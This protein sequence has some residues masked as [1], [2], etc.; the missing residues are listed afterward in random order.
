MWSNKTLAPLMVRESEAARQLLGL[1]S[2]SECQWRVV[3]ANKT[4][5]GVIGA[6]GGRERPSARRMSEWCGGSTSAR[7]KG[8]LE[9]IYCW[10]CT[11][12]I[13]AVTPCFVCTP[14]KLQVENRSGHNWTRKAEFLSTM[15][16]SMASKVNRANLY[17]K[18]AS[19][20]QISSLLVL[21]GQS[22]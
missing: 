16:T 4:N 14:C 17:F 12:L 20:G 7:L 2:S 21:L 13:K 18:S 11:A 22:F 19:V 5:N 9:L 3:A 6:V 1:Q 10:I 8:K 15:F